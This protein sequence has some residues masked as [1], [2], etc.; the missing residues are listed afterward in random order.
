[1][2]MTWA[3]MVS[4][5]LQKPD[6]QA[7]SI[8]VSHV[9]MCSQVHC[10]ILQTAAWKEERRDMVRGDGVKEDERQRRKEKKGQK[11]S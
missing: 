11:S 5:S 7:E 9:N 3:L 8:A 10:Y 1:M 6:G 2:V 4:R